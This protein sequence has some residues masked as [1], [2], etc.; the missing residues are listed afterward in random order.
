MNTL[1]KLITDTA[2]QVGIKVLSD[3]RCCQLL[4]W[5]LE[6]GGY[7]EASTHN[8]KLNQDIHIAQK[9]LNILGGE[10]PNAELMTLFNEYH[11]EL[12]NYLNKKSEKPQWLIYIEKYYK[13]NSYNN[14]K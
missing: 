13:L 3:A 11:S 5:V 9:R 2:Y 4:A 10:L 6:I 12:L 8:V 1:Y 14:N 7:T